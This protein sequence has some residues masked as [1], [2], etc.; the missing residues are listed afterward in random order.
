[1]V[2]QV[3]D[4]MTRLFL[5]ITWQIFDKNYAVLKILKRMLSPEILTFCEQ[6][7]ELFS[8]IRMEFIIH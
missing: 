1:M 2:I 5:K 4:Y 7:A 8:V 3:G 6:N